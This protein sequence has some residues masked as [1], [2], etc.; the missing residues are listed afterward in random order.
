[1]RKRLP[2][3]VAVVVGV[4]ALVLLLARHDVAAIGRLFSTVGWGLLLIVA[5]RAVALAFAGAGWARLVLPLVGGEFG[6]VLFLRW[7]R[8]S[9]NCL[10]P[11]AQ[12]G[13]DLIG[14]RLL[15]FCG[16][17]GSFA[18]ASI[19]VDLLVQVATQIGFAVIGL[20]VLVATGMAREI[21]VPVAGCLAIAAAALT[22]FYF[23]QRPGA[24][25][26][27]EK[28]LMKMAGRSPFGS[29]VSSLRLHESL[30]RLHRRPDLLFRS[31]MLHL[32]AWAPGVGEVWIALSFMGVKPGLAEALVLESLGQALRSF[33]FSI[34]GAL[35]V[36]EAGFLVLGQI[37]GLSPEVS[38]ALSLVKRVPDLALGIPGL[39][40]WHVLETKRFLAQRQSV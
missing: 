24:M 16:V 14:G 39:L 7:I 32:A 18:L 22:G 19:L 4:A 38:L 11:V 17:S 12:V 13:G 30:A 26:T 36:Q 2:L 5:L 3:L 35:G 25:V 10:L 34:P 27:I 23:A 6:T 21:A 29:R 40:A 33:G 8:E 20:A 9:I 31:A 1:M 15:T 37:Y 28:A